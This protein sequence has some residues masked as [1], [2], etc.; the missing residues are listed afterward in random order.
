KEEAIKW[1]QR[2][3]RGAIAT[4]AH[5]E[6]ANMLRR[7]FDDFRALGSAAQPSV[8]LSLTLAL[9]TALRSL[10]GYAAPE[11]EERLRRARELCAQSQDNS[12]R[13]NVEWELFQY[14]LVKGNIDAAREIAGRLFEYADLQ[15]DRRH[16]D[17]HLAEGMARF[18]FGDF[19]GA[20]ACF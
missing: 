20:R 19:I 1:W 6:A 11:V 4:S 9:A 12:N 8:E 15:D 5:E 16:A 3:A 18:H 2:G 10:H 13:F 17:A 14:N 7:A